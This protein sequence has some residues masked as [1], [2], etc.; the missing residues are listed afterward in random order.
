[1]RPGELVTLTM[2]ELDRAKSPSPAARFPDPAVRQTRSRSPLSTSLD[3]VGPFLQ[4]G[5]RFRSVRITN[6]R[7]LRTNVGR[8]SLWVF[9]DQITGTAK[10][11]AF[12]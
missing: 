6:D 2:R 9:R 10:T 3:P 1:M 7:A 8:K 12:E 4:I 11:H 5:Y